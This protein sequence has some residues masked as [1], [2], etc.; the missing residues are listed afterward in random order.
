MPY[1]P[2]GRGF[3]TGAMKPAGEYPADDMRSWDERRQPGN[4]EKDL[5]AVRELTA[6][7]EDKGIAVT[8]LALR[9]QLRERVSNTAA[10][11]HVQI[12]AAMVRDGL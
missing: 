8:Q 4:H 2:L 3:L 10:D 9:P 7:A 6:R 1:S 5:A 12:V 11:R